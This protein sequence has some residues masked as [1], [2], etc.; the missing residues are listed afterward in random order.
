MVGVALDL[1]RTSVE[2][3]DE[4]AA[5]DAAEFHRGRV[6]DRHA[7]RAVGGSRRVRHDRRLG[8]AAAG[9]EAHAR[10]RE[11]RAHHPQELAAVVA[12]E[13]IGALGELPLH[14]LPELGGV[15]AI[16]EAAP[17]GPALSHGHRGVVGGL[18]SRAA[19]GVLRRG[20]VHR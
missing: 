13:A 3:L 15:R 8:H 7:G 16:L 4:Q 19:C 12:L 9:R 5:R 1:D 14:E 18:A 17:V 6:V 10:E 2:A 11:G 20:G